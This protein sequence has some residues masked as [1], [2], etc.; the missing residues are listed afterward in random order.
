M[1]GL[2][3]GLYLPWGLVNSVAFLRS[4]EV[5]YR[6]TQP[7]ISTTNIVVAS[8]STRSEPSLIALVA[9]LF[10]MLKQT[11]LSTVS[12]TEILVQLPL[13][14][15]PAV[16]LLCL[17]GLAKSFR[18]SMRFGIFNFLWIAIPFA[19]MVPYFRDVRY[20]IVIA[21]C[22]SLMAAA[23]VRAIRCTSAKATLASVLLASLFIFLAVS[24]PISN[25]MYGGVQDASLELAH[26]GLANEKVLTNVPALTYYLPGLQLFVISSSDKPND[27]LG[28]LRSNGIRA[29][30]IIHNSRGAW[31]EIDTGTLQMI[32][33]LFRG[34]MSGGP[35]DFSWYEIYYNPSY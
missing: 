10:P 29:V 34:Y 4:I 11:G 8:N 26:L 15:T 16:F 32:R 31:P 23:T 27:V 2:G 35:S 12:Y 20:L 1:C 19:L 21:P 6:M 17:I 9:N 25:Q 18:S 24:I 5:L 3:I 13:W 28:I 7:S 22:Y 33:G 30:V 14:I